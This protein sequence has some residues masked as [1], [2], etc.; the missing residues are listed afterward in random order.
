MSE[1]IKFQCHIKISGK[2]LNELTG[3]T[4]TLMGNSKTIDENGEVVFDCEL[5]ERDK[6]KSFPITLEGEEL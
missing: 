5:Q 1:T 3:K 6:H 2:K 4:L